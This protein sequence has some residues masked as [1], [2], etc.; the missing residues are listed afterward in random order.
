M[1]SRIASP[2]P[3]NA[4]VTPSRWFLLARAY[5][6]ERRAGSLDLAV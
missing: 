6:D 2:E 3:P 1:R 4:G 5:D